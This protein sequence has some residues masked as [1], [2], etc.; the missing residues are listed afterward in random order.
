MLSV[1]KADDKE[2]EEEEEKTVWR[3][4]GSDYIGKRVRRYVFDARG[5]L[6]DAADGVV[7]GWLS[8]EESDYLA[9]ESGEPAPLWHMTYDDTRIGGEDLEE[10]EVQEALESACS[11]SFDGDDSDYDSDDADA[12]ELQKIKRLHA[13]ISTAFF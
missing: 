12:A 7:V 11:G 8:T 9:E 5:K 4:E 1:Q 6:H 3:T 13:S 2:A 10:H